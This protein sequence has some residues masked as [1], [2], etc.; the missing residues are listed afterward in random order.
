MSKENI[1]QTISNGQLK[2]ELIKLFESGMT[3]KSNSYELLRTK[4]KIEKQR[5]L[6]TF[7][8]V[9]LE[10]QNLK[11]KATNEQIQDNAKESLKKRLKIENRLDI[12]TS[13]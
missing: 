10:W 2:T 4:Y 5:C 12:R 1:K 11:D 6:K 8:S 9:L 3:A 13:K 7:D